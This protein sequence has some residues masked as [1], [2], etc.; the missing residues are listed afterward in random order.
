MEKGAALCSRNCRSPGV[1][2]WVI[3]LPSP[4]LHISCLEKWP[5][6]PYE[7]NMYRSL[8]ADPAVRAAA[9]CPVLQRSLLWPLPRW[10][11]VHRSEGTHLPSTHAVPS[12]HSPEP[13]NSCANGSRPIFKTCLWPFAQVHPWLVDSEC[14][15]W[16]QVAEIGGCAQ[17]DW[18][19]H[20][21]AHETPPDVT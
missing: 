12:D 19:L 6:L 2:E 11:R 17:V 18:G 7:Y 20:T 14:C 4:G 8:P 5:W 13:Q 9:L 15:V 21:N 10:V 1:A 16:R 3:W